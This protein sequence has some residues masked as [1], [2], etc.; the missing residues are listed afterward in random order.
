MSYEIFRTTADHVIGATDAALQKLGG[1]NVQL[2]ADFLDTPTDSARAAL[3][4]AAELGLLHENPTDTFKVSSPC[5]TYLITSSRES[6]AS[7]L[8]FV[9]EQYPPYR[10]FK[11]R[12]NITT[13]VVG[14]A[15]GQTRAVHS[16]TAHKDVIV[17]TLVE[18]GTYSKS[19]SSQG[20]G[21]YLAS[22]DDTTEYL[23]VVHSVI[24]DRENAELAVRRRIGLNNSNWL[25]QQD[26]LEHLVTAYQR[27]IDVEQDPRSPIVHAANATES[28]LAQVGTHYNVNL[29]NANGINAK[30]E[31]LSNSNHLATKHKFMLKYLGHVRNAA[32]HGVDNEVGV[33]WQVKANTSIE[34]VHIAQTLIGSIVEAI[35][36]TYIV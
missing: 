29:Q 32:H 25:N 12:L 1:V 22:E 5:S 7:V 28:F 21:L 16:I 4:M 26:V 31:R 8:R 9:L 18:L 23:K 27:L 17:A 13:G 20:A 36:G 2:V 33:A 30:A 35:N 24:Q 11:F 3:K 10:T 19:L 15:A 6:K 14:E 34:Y